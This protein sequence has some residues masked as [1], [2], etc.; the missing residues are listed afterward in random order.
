MQAELRVMASA[1]NTSGQQHMA[2]SASSSAHAAGANLFVRVP[3]AHGVRRRREES[4]AVEI[5]ELDSCTM[6]QNSYNYFQHHGAGAAPS[7]L[8]TSTFRSSLGRSPASRK[9][10]RT[11]VEQLDELCLQG[12]RG[13]V[14]GL[15]SAKSRGKGRGVRRLARESATGGGRRC[16][17]R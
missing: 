10:Q 11:L 4:A 13:R 16:T 9:R 8:R 3:H 17:H 1:A 7:L 2:T 15:D 5:E 6:R 12:S 14:V